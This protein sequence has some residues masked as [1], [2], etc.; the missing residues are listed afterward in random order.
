M[1]PGLTRAGLATAHDEPDLCGGDARE[2]SYVLQDSL[3]QNAGWYVDAGG[4]DPDKLLTAFRA[5]FG[6]T[7]STG[8]GTSTTTA[9]S[10]RFSSCRRTC[11]GW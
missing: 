1:R 6:N 3:D 5:F 7:P 11:S 4:L 8:W 2:L 9:R 10:I